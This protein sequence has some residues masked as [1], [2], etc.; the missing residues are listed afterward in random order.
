MPRPDRLLSE[1]PI[2][3]IIG[4]HNAQQIAERFQG[5]TLY[6]P[7]ARRAVVVHMASQGA[8]VAA[9]AATLGISTK[10]VKRYLRD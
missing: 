5:E 10:T 2:A 9:I 4:L 7:L 1:H 8:A 6:I 3:S